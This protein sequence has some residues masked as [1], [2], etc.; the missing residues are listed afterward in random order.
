MRLANVLDK[1]PEA[2]PILGLKHVPQR[3]R[4]TESAHGC[5][6]LR[7]SD[8]VSHVRYFCGADEATGMSMMSFSCRPLPRNISRALVPDHLIA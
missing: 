3:R 1:T 8:S 4:P 5:R 6:L 7:C 2:G